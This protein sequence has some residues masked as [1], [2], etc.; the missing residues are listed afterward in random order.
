LI[1]SQIEEIH[2]ADTPRR[3]LRTNCAIFPAGHWVAIPLLGMLHVPIRRADTMS[4][5]SEMPS[6]GRLDPAARPPE[7]DL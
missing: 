6:K 3:V 4:L 2:D 7:T 1:A 5:V